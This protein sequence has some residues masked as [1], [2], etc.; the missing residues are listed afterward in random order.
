MRLTMVEYELLPDDV[1]ST[2]NRW[3]D[4]MQL[5]PAIEIVFGEG[6][7]RLLEVDLEEPYV[8]GRCWALRGGPRVK[9]EFSWCERPLL[10]PPPACIADWCIA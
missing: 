7:A 4:H 8:H 9:P 3:W 2:F 5:P 10:F 1:R 6:F